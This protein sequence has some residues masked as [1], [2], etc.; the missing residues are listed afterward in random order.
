MLAHWLPVSLETSINGKPVR[1]AVD[2]E[3]PFRMNATLTVETSENVLFELK[4]RI[5]SW[6]KHVYL[7]G[8]SV[9]SAERYVTIYKR[10]MGTEKIEIEM[11]A[12]PHLVNRPSGLKTVEYGPLLFS[13]PIESEYCMKEYEKNGVERKF[14]YCDYELMP[15][16][17]WNYG[18]TDASF[19]VEEHPVSSI[20]FA[21]D[22]P[23]VILR[24][25]MVPVEWEWADG[26]ATVPAVKP[27]SNKSIGPVEERVLIPYGCAK[28][29]M[30]EMPK[31]RR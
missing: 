11:E 29:R 22:K 26:Y 24:T 25:R 21:S 8:K 15:K 27:V 28:L 7:N 19:E 2:S 6:A 30:T 4:L 16:S 12:K 14:P 1:I 13:L 3:Y 23:P 10:W 20:P 31:V 9:R 17:A 18:F 5:P